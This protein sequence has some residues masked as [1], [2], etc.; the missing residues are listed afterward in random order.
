VGE[1]GHQKTHGIVIA[2]AIDNGIE[3]VMHLHEVAD[4][5]FS[6]GARAGS[7]SVHRRSDIWQLDSGQRPFGA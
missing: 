5:S 2:I 4:N 7:I 1:L 6:A 3:S